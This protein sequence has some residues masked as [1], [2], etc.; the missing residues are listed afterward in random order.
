MATS[1][2][3]LNDREHAARI[4]KFDSRA[5]THVSR[6]K[7]ISTGDMKY[8]DSYEMLGLELAGVFG[9]F[10]FQSEYMKTDV[11][12]VETSNAKV[13]DHDFDGYYAYATW[14]ITGEIRPYH[15]VEGEFGRIIPNHSYGAWE[16]ALRYSTLDLNDITSIDAIK[17]GS[18]ENITAAINWYINPN[19]RIMFDI[20]S[21]N[22][23]EYAK[24]GKDFAPIPPGNGT[25]FVPVTNDDFYIFQM[26]YQVAF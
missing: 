10:T 5:E 6:A 1:G 14:F 23:D 12:R 24:P 11:N 26:R 18:A 8:V 22:N 4:V 9:P 7:F 15:I 25:T 21:V 19:H 13:V 20:T 3:D 16:V 2:S 17:G